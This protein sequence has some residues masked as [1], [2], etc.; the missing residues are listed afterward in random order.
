VTSDAGAR[1]SSARWQAFIATALI[2]AVAIFGYGTY[3]AIEQIERQAETIR[4]QAQALARNLAGVAQP[5][6]ALRQF[7]ELE[8]QLVPFAEFPG[9]EQILVTQADGQPVACVERTTGDPHPAFPGARVQPPAPGAPLVETPELPALARSI[10]PWR[11][12]SRWPDE[13]AAS[14][15]AWLPIGS[16]QAPGWV[17]VRVSLAPALSASA[18]TLIDTL[19]AGAIATLLAV[20]LAQLLLR[21][22]LSALQ[23]ATDFAGTLDTHFGERLVTGS[24]NREIVALGEA[25]TRTSLRLAEQHAALADSEARGRAMLH[26]SLDCV[27]ILDEHGRIVEF[28]PAAER[29]F[30]HERSRAL[31]TTLADLI[32]PEPSRAH[33]ARILAELESAAGRHGADGRAQL[34][35]ARVDGS[36]FP[37][38]LT[39]APMRVGRQR[40][41]TAFVRDIT[42]E[43][44]AE[45]AL[46]EAKDA[47]EAANRAKSDFIANMSHEIRTPLNGII[48]MTELAM[49]TALDDEQRTYLTTL[50]SSGEVLL[51]LINDLLDFSRI[52]AGRMQIESTEF[53][54]RDLVA[55][56]IRPLA[57]L[58]H[59]KGLELN[60]RVDDDV[61]QRLT[62]DAARIG[63]ILV[64]LVGNAI[65]FSPQGEVEVTCELVARTERDVELEFAI[66]DTG[67]GIPTDK[68]RLIFDAFAQADTSATR[69]FG[70]TGL[71]LA[72]CRRLC[73]MMDGRIWVHSTP[74]R[75]STFHFTLI[76]GCEAARAG[77]PRA[78]PFAGLR[79][80][81][82]DDHATTRRHTLA[83]LHALGVAGQAVADGDAAIAALE[84]P[85]DGDAPGVVLVDADLGTTS[86]FELVERLR[87]TQG[88]Q[89]G[90]VMMLGTRDAGRQRRRCAELGIDAMIVKPVMPRD[91][92][93]ALMIALGRAGDAIHES[94]AGTARPLRVLLAEDNP[95]NQTVASR[96]LEK[97]GH[98][99]AI[100]ADGNEALAAL[101]AETFDVVLMD[102]Q[103]PGL[104]G[105]AATRAQRARERERG[106]A[107]GQAVR[108][109]IVAMTA[110][111]FAEDRQACQSAGMDGY[112]TKPVEQ[113]DLQAMLAR[114]VPRRDATLPSAPAIAVGAAADRPVDRTPGTHDPAHGAATPLA[115]DT[116]SDADGALVF[117]DLPAFTCDTVVD[118]FGDDPELLAKLASI[119]E[120]NAAEVLGDLDAAASAGDAKRIEFA[121]HT[122]KGTL[123]TL[124]AA[125]ASAVGQRIE[126][127]AQH[128]DVAT[129]VRHLPRLRTEVD[130]V[131]DVLAQSTTAGTPIGS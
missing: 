41:F 20:G 35:A 93:G 123:A 79:A 76:A 126:S 60:C 112:L 111:A 99:V 43:R 37:I 44:R 90:V 45:Q 100:A 62:G 3:L 96:M 24:G 17:R 4:E 94:G 23:R 25:L 8:E 46:L 92:E 119:F 18:H 42:R 33:F 15:R 64:N 114:V 82:V 1:P 128:G 73:M 131:L 116:P 75:G 95:V 74:G 6:F 31:G 77:G 91:L 84:A 121:A 28:N 81:V 54:I 129:A 58:A 69:Q 27:I 117:D 72:I 59:A 88:S 101:D 5:R 68:Q 106:A 38:E 49:G 57:P 127:A 53:A 47:A 107:A 13:R 12:A 9:V 102:L 34:I 115:D 109:P 71:G 89:P 85:D 110:H 21:R 80:L 125:V 7:G 65:K 14:V 78:E 86:G 105:I 122:I 39:I 67:I 50:R 113:A 70:G 87:A 118:Q 97:L 66:R 103:M 30:G 56:R 130:R 11:E 51:A 40:M 22:P 124:G 120:R 83:H 10:L 16:D 19:F 61:P 104:G 63:Q 2:S 55:E 52:E 26:A 108:I 32:L 29:T 98:E 48:G 36:E